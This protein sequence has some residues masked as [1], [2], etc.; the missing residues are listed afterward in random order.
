MGR[1]T[2]VVLLGFFMAGCNA[3]SRPNS[4]STRSSLDAAVYEVYSALLS[5]KDAFGM[6]PGT[7]VII[8]KETS[9]DFMPNQISKCFQSHEEYH[10]DLESAVALYRQWQFHMDFKDAIHDF[11]L[12]N[13]VPG[14]LTRQLMIPGPY[15]ILSSNQIN[16]LEVSGN[17]LWADF[18][19]NYPSSE[20]YVAFS[21]VGFNAERTRAIVSA[22]RICGSLCG[23]GRTYAMEKVNGKWVEVR[24]G[25]AWIS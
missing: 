20:G 1:Y 19:K 14:E 24:A 16:S 9:K 18:Y 4:Q 11:E 7:M 13:K 8:Q 5:T 21:T 22:Y 6:N 2:F 10:F 12:E 3:A 23:G 15:E 25:C 17:Y